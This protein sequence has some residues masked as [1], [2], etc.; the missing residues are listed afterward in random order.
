[1]NDQV[2]GDSRSRRRRNAVPFANAR[3]D[4]QLDLPQVLVDTRK[5]YPWETRVLTVG[6]LDR[7]KASI[8]Y[9]SDTRRALLAASTV[10]PMTISTLLVLR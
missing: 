4:K 7:I 9:L 3:M 5:A 8:C 6:F 10:V 2:D 1:M